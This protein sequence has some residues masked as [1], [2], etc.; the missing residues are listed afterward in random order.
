[1][2]RDRVIGRTALVIT[3]MCLVGLTVTGVLA[4][5]GVRAHLGLSPI[6]P[7]SYAVGS[8]I[9]LP[10]SIYAAT[11]YTLILFARSSCDACQRAKSVLADLAAQVANESN[12]R[13]ILVTGMSNVEDDAAYGRQLGVNEAS[14]IRLDLTKL[15]LRQVPTIVLVDRNGQVERDWEGPSPDEQRAI[16]RDVVSFLRVH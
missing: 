10:S 16:T 4:I 13:V 9:D 2:N 11:P 5:P 12:A 3:A 14:Q 8:H 7:I 1:M 15:Q 6:R